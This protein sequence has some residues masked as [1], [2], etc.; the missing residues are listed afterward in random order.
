MKNVVSYE[1]FKD[2][3]G[4]PKPNPQFMTAIEEIETNPGIFMLGEDPRAESFL[5][6]FYK[7][8]VG[9]CSTSNQ[10][11]TRVKSQEIHPENTPDASPSSRHSDD[12]KNA[13]SHLWRNH[14]KLKRK[15]ASESLSETSSELSS[16]TSKRDGSEEIRD[17]SD[18]YDNMSE[19]LINDSSATVAAMD[20]S[21][22]DGAEGL[23]IATIPQDS[24]RIIESDPHVDSKLARKLQ[25][26]AMKKAM[27]KAAKREAKRLAKEAERA[28]RRARREAKRE[29]KRLHRLEKQRMLQEQQLGLIMDEAQHS[30]PMDSWVDR[31]HLDPVFISASRHTS[32]ATE[33]PYD[34]LIA[35][36][37][38]SGDWSSMIDRSTSP[39]KLDDYEK[40][41]LSVD[42]IT[43][44]TAPHT[45]NDAEESIFQN[46]WSSASPASPPLSPN[47][48]PTSDLKRTLG[49]SP[50]V[51]KVDYSEDL[52]SKAESESEEL[53]PK[54]RVKVEPQHSPVLPVNQTP[55]DTTHPDHVR[56]SAPESRTK[57]KKNIGSKTRSRHSHGTSQNGTTVYKG[58]ATRRRRLIDSSDDS[59]STVG[60]TEPPEPKTHNRLRDH[61]VSV[62]PTEE[63]VVDLPPLT[64]SR[65]DH[66][67]SAVQAETAVRRRQKSI[68]S[69]TLESQAKSTTPVSLAND[70]PGDTK[71]PQPPEA[72]HLPTSPD[73]TDVVTQLHHLCRDLKASLIRGHE[74]FS[75]AV[76]HLTRLSTIPVRLP[77]LAQ[78]WD[79][80][81]C[82]KKCRRYKLSAEVREAAQGT[83]RIFQAIQSSATKEE[84]ALA[85]SLLAAHLSRPV[86][87]QTERANKDAAPSSNSSSSRDQIDLTLP[88]STTKSTPP[89]SVVQTFPTTSAT[90]DTTFTSLQLSPPNLEAKSNSLNADLAAKVDDMLSLIRATDQRMAAAAFSNPRPPNKPQLTSSLSTESLPGI[91]T[92]SGRVAELGHTIRASAVAAAAAHMHD[93]EDEESVMSRVEQVAAFE[94]ASKMVSSAPRSPPPPPPPLL[95]S[96]ALIA[97]TKTGSFAVKP[98][99]TSV[100]LDLDSR[101]EMLITGP[102][103]GTH[104][105]PT[106]CPLSQSSRPPELN[107]RQDL[108]LRSVG[109]TD[110]GKPI[111]IPPALLAQRQT[112]VEKIAA[113]RASALI[114]PLKP[115]Q[116]SKLTIRPQPPLSAVQPESKD[117][118][119][120]DL[121]GV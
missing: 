62:P 56:N 55:A 29:L 34:A 119:L 53:F 99:E 40:P 69:D 15:N 57:Q 58:M 20:A 7:F 54:K 13:V 26:K 96:T 30:S 73:P 6:Q 103:P 81:D 28:E 24:N 87:A 45:P 31:P 83:L 90:S 110:T 21:A 32:P 63:P 74:N 9:S 44:K 14:T 41:D 121:L 11:S 27:K 118:E 33:S 111:N 10:P 19:T 70:A 89:T 109:A 23:S 60:W 84:L 5:L 92:S 38:G 50:D 2:K 71:E 91:S 66:R 86:T 16:V 107:K 3:W 48:S 8:K 65:S 64:N 22:S 75:L 108:S 82:I 1:E 78:A 101:I 105:K 120:Y 116:Q 61:T 47:L 49:Q 97:T 104:S 52:V 88:A 17:I 117:D 59:D 12:G 76:Q 51:S 102:K 106:R 25:K 67:G 112:I 115:S 113:N 43:E 80:M 18:E 77:Q 95:T 39:L 79:L 37:F 35:A 114:S 100:D 72:P 68:K 93:E 85:Q 36:E 4:K 94:A 46:A 98:L 42:L